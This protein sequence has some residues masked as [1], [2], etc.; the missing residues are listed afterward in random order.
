MEIEAVIPFDKRRSKVLTDE[1]FVFVLY[2]GEIRIYGI[3][4]G[5]ELT[6]ETYERI[7]QEV[8]FKRVKERVLYLLKSRDRTE[9]EIRRKL[10]EGYYPEEAIEYALSFLKEY[11][12]IDDE[13]YGR[14]YIRTYGE[15]NSK[16]QLEFELRG[17]GLEKETISRLLKEEQVSEE[18]QIRRYLRK[19][20]Y[21]KGVTLRK[22]QAKLAAGLVRRGF[23]YDTVCDVMGESCNSSDRSAR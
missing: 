4:A 8:L 12:F 9:L 18:E 11:R 13:D 14:R 2:K 15:K 10:K 20:G 19:K 6:K 1:G 22:E 23:S 7:L 17:K 5:K 3:E 21:E 16:K